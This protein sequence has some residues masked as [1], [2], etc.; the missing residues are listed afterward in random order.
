[1][2]Y[3]ALYDLK[4]NQRIPTIELERKFPKDKHKISRLALLELPMNVLRS[5]FKDRKEQFGS[6]LALKRS[7]FS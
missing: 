3:R 4:F 1:M 6:L 5:V 7:L 2:T